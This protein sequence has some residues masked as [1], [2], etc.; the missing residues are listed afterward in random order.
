MTETKPCYGATPT[1]WA[2]FDVLLGLTSDLLPVVSNPKAEI[3]PESKMKDKGK[4]PSRY[5]RHKQVAGLA[6]WTQYT[7]TDMDMER[8]QQQPDYGICIQTRHVRALDVDVPD[9]TKAALIAMEIERVLGFCPPIRY[10]DNSWK[11]LMAFR[12]AG[13]MPKRVI[14]VREKLV[15]G[16]G[17]TTEP[18]WLIEFLANGQQFVACGTHSSGARI[19]WKWNGHADFPTITLE[20]FD[21]LWKVLCAKFACA[22]STVGA[23]RKRGEY[24]ETNDATANLIAEKGLDLG[25]GNDGQLFIECPWKDEHSMDSGITETAYF[26]RGTG[27]YEL[28]HFKCM[29]ASHSGKSDTDFEEA[30]GLRD[31]MFGV[32]DVAVETN[33]KGEPV[34]ALPKWSRTKQG[35]VEATLYNLRLALERPDVCGRDVRNDR[36]T[37]D[38]MVRL[39][40]GT[41]RPMTDGDAVN[42]RE[43]LERHHNFKSIGRELMR[44]AIIA[45]GERHSFDTAIE[46]LETLPDWDGKPRID[47]FM[48]DCFAAEPG[49]YATAVGRYLWTALAG[50]CLVPGIKADMALILQGDQG[51][52]KSTAIAALAPW[53]DTFAELGLGDKETELARRMRGKLVIELGELRG[54]YSKEFEAIKAFLVRRFDQWVPKYR[55]RAI[56][57]ARRCI[58][59]ATTNH[60]EILVDETGN[61]RFLPIRVE[62][63][64]IKKIKRDRLQ[65]WAEARDLFMSHGIQWA[66]AE[67][68]GKEE[69]HKFTVHDSWE[70]DIATWLEMEDIDGAKNGQREFLKTNDVMR[71]ALN[72]DA[73]NANGGMEKRVAKAL[74]VLGWGMKRMRVEGR[75]QRVYVKL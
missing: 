64:D 29:H 38:D 37:D 74:K 7:A 72:I 8:W 5:N 30:T 35:Q 18:A 56:S 11:F 60:S 66:E 9:A 59:L 23:L 1:E 45:H 19:N 32:V 25:V 43:H 57:F 63:A 2:H 13:D 42:L 24:V 12:I 55:E 36:F 27:G 22:P 40:G 16:E 26:P 69:H 39:P 34:Q 10:R 31:D 15:D 4:V 44:D 53:E 3:S 48:A 49:P 75:Q 54:F 41:W 46:W 52:I 51:V 20:Q 68:L 62:R 21:A 58:F 61:R 65:L 67:T 6:G 33:E 14:R 70:D 73:R 28:G 47:N 50:R 71:E 17:K